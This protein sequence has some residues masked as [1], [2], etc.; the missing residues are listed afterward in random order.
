MIA[1]DYEDRSFGYRLFLLMGKSIRSVWVVFLT[2]I[3]IVTVFYGIV[4]NAF[5][6]QGVAI[7]VCIGLL[8][9]I[10]FLSMVDIREERVKFSKVNGSSGSKVY[11]ASSRKK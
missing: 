1:L 7:L 5:D 8:G 9:L 4:L 11:R 6:S 3:L 2:I 10:T